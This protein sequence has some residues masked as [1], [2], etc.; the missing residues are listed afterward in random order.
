MY[1]AVRAAHQEQEQEQEQAQEQE[2]AV[3]GEAVAEAEAAAAAAAGE[4]AQ[5]QEQEQPGAQQEQE[6]LPVPPPTLHH[7]HAEA[8]RPSHSYIQPVVP[9]PLHASTQL[10]DPLHLLPCMQCTH[11]LITSYRLET[12]MP[13]LTELCLFSVL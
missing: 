8:V 12:L 5:E 6:P 2:A 10:S 13:G 1:E 11:S 3:A 9:I 7:N 4:A